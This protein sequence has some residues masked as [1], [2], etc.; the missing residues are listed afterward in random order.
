MYIYVYMCVCVYVCVC[1]SS[2]RF[3]KERSHTFLT[4]SLKDSMCPSRLFVFST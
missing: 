2:L 4:V 3:S 1:I